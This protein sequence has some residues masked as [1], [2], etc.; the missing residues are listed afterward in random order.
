MKR[1]ALSVLASFLFAASLVA[2][3]IEPTR[4]VDWSPFFAKYG[5]LGY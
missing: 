1:Y 3:F 5:G 4:K 2:W